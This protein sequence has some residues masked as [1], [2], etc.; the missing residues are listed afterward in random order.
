MPMINCTCCLISM[1][2]KL[3]KETK[4]PFN[5]SNW[6]LIS[7]YWKFYFFICEWLVATLVSLNV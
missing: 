1:N 4:N 7:Q 5:L 6:N 2:G 3:A